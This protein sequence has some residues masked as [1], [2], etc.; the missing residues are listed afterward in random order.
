MDD[1]LEKPVLSI[2]WGKLRK[3]LP[4]RTR[5]CFINKTRV[6]L[7]DNSPMATSFG[8]MPLCKTEYFQLF[9]VSCA[10][11]ITYKPSHFTCNLGRF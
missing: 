4:W 9:C 3:H 10:N 1:I 5:V 2:S 7:F 11:R 8:S 6:F